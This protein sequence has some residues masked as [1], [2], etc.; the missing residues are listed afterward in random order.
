LPFSDVEFDIAPRLHPGINRG[1]LPKS[2]NLEGLT[3]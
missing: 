2:L 1:K 3:G